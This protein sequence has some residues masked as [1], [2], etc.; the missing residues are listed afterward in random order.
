MSS[1]VLG[2]TETPVEDENKGSSAS[3]PASDGAEANEAK[4]VSAATKLKRRASA[5]L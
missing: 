4:Q 3:I 5:I 1:R 2:V